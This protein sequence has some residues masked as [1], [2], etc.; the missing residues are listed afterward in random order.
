MVDRNKA[1]RLAPIV[2]IACLGLLILGMLSC[3]GGARGGG[4]QAASMGAQQGSSSARTASSA[5][6]IATT[7][8]YSA[9]AAQVRN[10]IAPYE[11]SVAV[12]FVSLLPEGGGFSVDSGVAMR[13]ASMLKVPILCCLLEEAAAGNISLNET[14]AVASEDVVGGTGTGLYAGEV[15]TVERLAQ[16]MIAE[17]DNTASNT[18]I[19][20][21]GKDRINAYFQANGLDQTVLNR[22]FMA[23][24]AS[25][26][27]LTSARD[28]A[29]L[30]KR[31]A[32]NDIGSA[33][34]CWLAQSML[35][36]QSDDDGMPQGLPAGMKAG[37]KTGSLPLARHDGGIIYNASGQPQ[38]VLVVMTEDLGE[39]DANKLIAQVTEIVCAGL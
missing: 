7:K 39:Y 35:R 10:A 21:L 19:S 24:N 11:G 16:L 15:L 28:L 38:C 6:T 32:T 4:G 36:Q 17:S 1:Y 2:L 22:S 8:N 14:R 23:S 3:A 30:F 9:L 5:S 29:T 20:L 18:L 25:G 26:D 13:S 12:E 34:L 33:N 37:H 31:I 27:N